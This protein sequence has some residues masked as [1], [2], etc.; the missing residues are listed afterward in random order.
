MTTETITLT[1]DATLA[2]LLKK[3]ANKNKKYVVSVDDTMVLNV[4]LGVV[5]KDTTRANTWRAENKEAIKHGK[6]YTKD[7]FDVLF[8]DLMGDD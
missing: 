3:I 8:Q 6:S 7:E 4:T 2:M 5:D 1:K